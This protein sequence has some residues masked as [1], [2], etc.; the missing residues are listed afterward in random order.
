MDCSDRERIS[1]A[2]EELHKTVYDEELGRCPILLLLNKHDISTK[3]SREEIFLE[4]EL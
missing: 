4:L 1:I 3:M 2:K